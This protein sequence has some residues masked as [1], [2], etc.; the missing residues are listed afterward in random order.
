VKVKKNEIL[1]I[2]VSRPDIFYFLPTAHFLKKLPTLIAQI[3]KAPQD[4]P[5]SKAFPK[6]A[7]IALPFDN[8]KDFLYCLIEVR[9]IY[10]LNNHNKY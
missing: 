9:R 1:T 3:A 2:Q 5:E 6:S 10:L 8:F 4:N 7:I